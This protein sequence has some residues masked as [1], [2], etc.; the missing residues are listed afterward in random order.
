MAHVP[1]FKELWFS[2]HAE[3]LE[4][5]HGVCNNPS[6]ARHVKNILYDV[7]RFRD[8]SLE[9]IRSIWPRQEFRSSQQ[10]NSIL[11]RLER[12]FHGKRRFDEWIKEHPGPQEFLNRLQHQNSVDQ[13]E[14]LFAGMR[15]L[16]NL[17]GFYAE[18]SET[19]LTDE[20]SPFRRKWW[21]KCKYWLEP[22]RRLYEPGGTTI[23]STKIE[24]I[25]AAITRS[26]AS[27]K[28]LDFTPDASSM[29][30]QGPVLEASKA[31][32]S[33]L[34]SLSVNFNGRSWSKVFH[35][36]IFELL[37]CAK[38]LE[39]LYLGFQGEFIT[40]KFRDELAALLHEEVV[41]PRLQSLVLRG[42]STRS[43]TLYR[44]LRSH[45]KTLK[46]LNM[47]SISLDG[48]GNGPSSELLEFVKSEME[49]DLVYLYPLYV[50]GTNYE[51]Q[52]DGW[53]KII[54]PSGFMLPMI[55]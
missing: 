43:D 6:L 27:I 48:K 16:P 50:I 15:K 13:A 31:V 37:H 47:I 14:L 44:I 41:P 49:L 20:L 42:L 51:F 53:W 24:H 10:A 29:L 25:M 2:P 38:E 45:S 22:R 36:G 4:V 23:N 54:S 9:E 1:L 19:A 12:V 39:S 18:A 11:R 26:G 35:L 28:I 32:F 3:D 52:S 33:K 40:P 55:R 30:C 5:F 7:T 21:S 17:S 8:L 34:T 46:C